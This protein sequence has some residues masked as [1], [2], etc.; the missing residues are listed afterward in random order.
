MSVG[1]ITYSTIFTAKGHRL[2]CGSKEIIELADLNGD[3]KIGTKLSRR[4][5]NTYELIYKILMQELNISDWL[6]FR[7]NAAYSIETFICG[8][9]STFNLLPLCINGPNRILL[10]LINISRTGKVV[11]E[12]VHLIPQPISTLNVSVVAMITIPIHSQHRSRPRLTP[13]LSI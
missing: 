11:V 9:K 5:C 4:L 1:N 7:V 10:D 3:E 6:L 2:G 13:R 8:Q 12:L